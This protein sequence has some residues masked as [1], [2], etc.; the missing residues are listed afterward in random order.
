MFRFLK[1][2]R[3]YNRANAHLSLTFFLS[4]NLSELFLVSCGGRRQ[5]LAFL[6]GT[7]H[8]LKISHLL[9]YCMILYWNVSPLRAETLFLQAISPVPSTALA[10]S[11]L[12]KH[13]Y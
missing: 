7:D 1:F 4:L 3:I 6:Y 5:K 12:S 10:H 8:H 2:V 9:V 13:K 11:R